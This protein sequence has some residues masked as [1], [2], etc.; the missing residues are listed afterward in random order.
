MYS[1]L[2]GEIKREINLISLLFSQNRQVQNDT[3]TSVLLSYLNCSSHELQNGL[4]LPSNLFL[5][6]LH[7]FSHYTLDMVS[8]LYISPFTLVSPFQTLSLI[9]SYLPNILSYSRL[10]ECY[11]LLFLHGN[12]NPRSNTLTVTSPVYPVPVLIFISITKDSSR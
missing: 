5:Y 11:L 4:L 2:I 10:L 6:I 7:M 1:N 3:S 12:L 8:L 9:T